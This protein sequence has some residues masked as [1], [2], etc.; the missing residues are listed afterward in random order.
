MRNFLTEYYSVD[1]MKE[2]K[3]GSAYG[4]QGKR[5]MHL[6]FWLGKLQKGRTW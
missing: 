6:G 4:T 5:E 3:M 1:R 2:D